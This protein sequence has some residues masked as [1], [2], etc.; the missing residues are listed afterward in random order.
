[1][2]LLQNETWEK[3]SLVQNY[4]KGCFVYGDRDLVFL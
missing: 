1:M 2:V 3:R 4:G